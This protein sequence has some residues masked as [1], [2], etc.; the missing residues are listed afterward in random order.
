M[1]PAGGRWTR[2][3]ARQ[4]PDERLERAATPVEIMDAAAEKSSSGFEENEMTAQRD[5]AN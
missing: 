4:T 3:A 1:R 5:G 2:D